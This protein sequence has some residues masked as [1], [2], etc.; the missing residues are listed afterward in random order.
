[1]SIKFSS[2]LRRFAS[3]CLISMSLLLLTQ[4]AAAET[5][6]LGDFAAPDVISYGNSFTGPQN[7]FTDWFG[8]SVNESSYNGITAS[9]SFAQ[10][11]GIDQ[12]TTQLYGGSITGEQVNVGSLIAT[13]DSSQTSFSNVIQTTSVIAPTFLSGDYLIKISGLTTGEFGGSYIG[14]ANI[15]PVPLPPNS[16]LMAAGLGV[17][18]LIRRKHNLKRDHG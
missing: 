2:N 14:V 11:F 12:L 15:S 7:Q 13:G 4:T 17:L 6:D 18:A 16:P 8:F 10:V 9:I 1:M 5:L 3:P